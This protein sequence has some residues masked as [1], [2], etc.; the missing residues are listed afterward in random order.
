MNYFCWLVYL[1]YFLRITLDLNPHSHRAYVTLDRRPH[2]YSPSTARA[3]LD[4]NPRSYSPFDGL[5]HS[6]S[7]TSAML[8]SS[9]ALAHTKSK[10][11]SAKLKRVIVYL[12]ALDP[13]PSSGFHEVKKKKEKKM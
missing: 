5:T 8:T 1:S 13:N 4:R 11:K 10:P 7:C 3:T 6:R 2:V 12:H 9:P